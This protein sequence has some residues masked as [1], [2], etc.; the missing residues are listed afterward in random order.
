[1]QIVVTIYKRDAE[2]CE[3]AGDAKLTDSQLRNL[4]DALANC[5]NDWIEENAL[6][7]AGGLAARSM[8]ADTPRALPADLCAVVGSDA[9][10]SDAEG[11]LT[12]HGG[13]PAEPGV[14]PP[15][16]E[17]EIAYAVVSLAV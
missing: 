1:M 2:G 6:D 5:A 11:S 9:T 15:K 3:I 16:L 14:K 12:A 8:P 7:R 17:S 13:V 10:A 4:E